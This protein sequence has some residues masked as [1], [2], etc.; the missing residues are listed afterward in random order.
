MQGIFFKNTFSVLM[1][2]HKKRNFFWQNAFFFFITS[3]FSLTS[4]KFSAGKI[5]NWPCKFSCI[6]KKI[7][8]LK[9]MKINTKSKIFIRKNSQLIMLILLHLKKK[10]SPLKRIKIYLFFKIKVS[11]VSSCSQCIFPKIMHTKVT[12]SFAKSN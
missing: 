3:K 1:D 5:P 7:S 2:I 6:F 9:R 10:I 11:M 12:F 8:Q 4:L